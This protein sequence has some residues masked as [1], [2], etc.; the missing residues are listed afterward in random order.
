[1]GNWLPFGE[2]LFKFV[3]VESNFLLY[4]LYRADEKLECME[5]YCV[6]YVSICIEKKFK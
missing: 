1:M 5:I 6:F 4:F 3:S 2:V